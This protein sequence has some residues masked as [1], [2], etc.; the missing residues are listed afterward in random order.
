MRLCAYLLVSRIKSRKI[1]LHTRYLGKNKWKY[2]TA[3]QTFLFEILPKL[4]GFVSLSQVVR[5][6]V[7]GILVPYIFGEET[8]EI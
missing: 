4:A 8:L 1:K 5:I 2:M 7:K 3:D 6:S